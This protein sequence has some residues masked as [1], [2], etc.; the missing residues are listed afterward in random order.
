MIGHKLDQ[1]LVRSDL[2]IRRQLVEQ[3]ANRT[4]HRNVLA[5]AAA[6]HRIGLPR[7]AALERANQRAGVI[8]DE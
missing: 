2:T 4:H 1:R 7:L 5:L 8:V 6:A 3:P